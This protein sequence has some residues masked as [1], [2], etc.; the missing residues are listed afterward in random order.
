MKPNIDKTIS[1]TD[2]LWQGTQYR[3][4]Q[5]VIRRIKK[6]KKITSTADYQINRLVEMGKTTEQIE[7]TIKEAIDATWPEMFELYD[8]VSNW[9]YVR[10]KD[11]Y[12]QINARYIPPEKNQW[13]QNI[14]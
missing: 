7:K 3:I 12:E 5:D 2:A 8:E 14:S 6:T 13:L 9:E 4:M 1:R 10:N 11:I